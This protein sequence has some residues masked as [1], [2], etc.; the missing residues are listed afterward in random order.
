MQGNAWK[1]PQTSSQAGLQALC[2]KLSD[3]APPLA[4]RPGGGCWAEAKHGAELAHPS[5]ATFLFDV[6]MFQF[7]HPMRQ[8][9]QAACPS[10]L[11]TPVQLLAGLSRDF[12]G[13]KLPWDSFS[14]VPFQCEQHRGEWRSKWGQP[15]GTGKMTGGP[16]LP[17]WRVWRTS[18]A[19]VRFRGLSDSSHLPP[20]S[21]TRKPW[22]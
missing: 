9:P 7:R 19:A 17:K 16:A 21:V 10:S 12:K 11:F 8:Q 5:T 13:G 18:G 14:K 1:H 22:S 4:R 3:P 2:A 6:L 20:L 15:S